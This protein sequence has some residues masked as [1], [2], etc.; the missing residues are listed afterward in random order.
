LDIPVR[1]HP[2]LART[3]FDVLRTVVP[4]L[5]CGELP[6]LF[7][8]LWRKIGRETNLVASYVLVQFHYPRLTMRLLRY[9]FF[10]ALAVVVCVANAPSAWA[11]S[12]PARPVK[13]IVGFAA[14]GG[15]D[16]LAR[17]LAQRLGDRL[18]QQFIVE[19]RPG[20]GSN[21]ATEA[22]VRSPA[23]GYTLL[24]FAPANAINASLYA[25]LNFNF[26]EDIVQ[27]AGIVRLPNVMTV[28][29]AVPAKSVAEFIAFAKANAGK[30][31]Y[32]SGGVGTASHMAAELFKVMTG[33]EMVHVPFRG[34]GPVMTALLQGEV[35]A[36]FSDVASQLSHIKSGQIRPLAVT[37][38]APSSMLPEVPT[39]DATVSGY[40]ASSWFGIGAPKGTPV[41]IINQLNRE[42]NAALG[43]PPLRDKLLEMGGQILTGTP[44]EIRKLVVDE[45]DKWAKVVKFSGAKVE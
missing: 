23:D 4:A 11:Q 44:E 15:A 10:A 17:L 43:E 13:I 14:G 19:A 34:N 32:G 20:A 28:G 12:Y 2:P 45:T 30:V 8:G 1:R 37:T 7:A 6:P 26:I 25:K 3:A 24:L 9:C 42:I 35:H 29:N 39:V 22:V 38:K 31:N 41:E 36:N 16:I 33:I 40:E 21:I 27:V 18:G 5:G